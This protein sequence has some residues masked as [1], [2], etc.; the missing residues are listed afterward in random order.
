MQT[1]EYMTLAA[2]LILFWESANNAHN[3]DISFIKGIACENSDSSFYV[4]KIFNRLRYSKV[5]HASMQ[6]F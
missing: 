4:R 6:S 2:Y 1:V 3:I 5:N